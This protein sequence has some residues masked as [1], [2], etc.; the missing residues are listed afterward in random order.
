MTVLAALLGA[1]LPVITVVQVMSLCP[2]ILLGGVMTAF[3]YC[4]A[5]WLPAAVYVGVQLAMSAWLT[6]AAMTAM[7]TVSGA[8]PALMLLPG[9]QRCRPFFDQIRKALLFYFA[10]MLAAV[11]IAYM[12]FGG[13][14]V[15][16]FMD[17]LR[18]QFRYIPDSALAPFVEAINSTLAGSAGQSASFTITDYRASLMGM[19]D[20]MQ[21]T[22]GQMLPGALLSG[23]LVS[24]VLTVLWGNWRLARRGMATAHSFVGMTGWHLPG[25]ITIGTLVLWAVSF[26]LAQG[27]IASGAAVY[28][29]VHQISSFTFLF[30]ATAAMDRRFLERGMSVGGRKALIGIMIVL[31]L[32]FRDVATM[33]M[34]VGILSALFGRNGVVRKAMDK[35][36]TN[37]SDPGDP[38][39]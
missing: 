12:S 13:N 14:M 5:G 30:Q 35:N 17:V 32:L 37:G 38:D 34:I 6:G 29:T 16:R 21:Q 1:L 10:G 31:A 3:F 36:D 26:L 15:Q 8:L 24:A 28:A 22:Y 18:Q 4:S 25:T 20:L 11:C 27:G 19:L 23:A 9:M 33:L 7:Q 39:K 2:I